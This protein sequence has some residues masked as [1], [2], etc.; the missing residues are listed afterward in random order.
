MEIYSMEGNCSM[1]T[2]LMSAAP[3]LLAQSLDDTIGFYQDKLGFVL[4]FKYDDYAAMKRDDVELHF[5]AYPS[6]NPDQN[7]VTCYLTVT[8]VRAL[9]DEYKAQGVIHPNGA[10]TDQPWGMR[11][12]VVLDENKNAIRFGEAISR[13]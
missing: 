2:R 13:D 12:F 6:L 11:E 1:T 9:Y 10:L 4:A 7:P 8:G 5:S 3:V